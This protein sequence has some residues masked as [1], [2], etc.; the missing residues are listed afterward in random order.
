MFLI[1]IIIDIL[2][3]LYYCKNDKLKK[4]NICEMEE[5]FLEKIEKINKNKYKENRAGPK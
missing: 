2:N 1:I 4:E 3:N 5:K